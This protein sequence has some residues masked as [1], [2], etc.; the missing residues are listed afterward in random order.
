[1]RLGVGIKN[2][3]GHSNHCNADWEL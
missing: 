3:G 2:R 1:M